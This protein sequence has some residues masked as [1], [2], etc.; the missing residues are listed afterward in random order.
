[1]AYHSVTLLD[2]VW[3]ISHLWW[4]DVFHWTSLLTM[5]ALHSWKGD[6]HPHWSQATVVHTNT[7]K[8]IEWQSKVIHIYATLPPQHQIKKG[9]TNRVTNF[10]YRP[11]VMA[12]TTMLNSCGHDTSGWFRL[13]A[14]DPD[15][16]T[17]Y[18]AMS[19]GTP[20]ANFHFQDG[21]LC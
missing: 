6:N 19:T 18:Q 3:K 15:F 1:M 21:L 16:A 13:Y 4:G 17:T 20:Y 9:S 14:S 8:I 5:E 12:L 7:R 11:P 10:L 2:V